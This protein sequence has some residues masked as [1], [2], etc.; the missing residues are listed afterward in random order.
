MGK[1][2]FS[3]VH[4]SASSSGGTG[5]LRLIENLGPPSVA[6]KKKMV[7]TFRRASRPRRHA[8]AIASHGSAIAKQRQCGWDILLQRQREE[9]AK[10]LSGV[11]SAFSRLVKKGAPRPTGRAPPGS[12]SHVQTRTGALQTPDTRGTI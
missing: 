3:M 9:K 4:G 7:D 6:T 10:A 8:Q 1:I 5:D 12:P 11:R 2:K